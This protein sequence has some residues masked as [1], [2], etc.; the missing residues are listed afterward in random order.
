MP[1][2]GRASVVKSRAYVHPVS[3]RTFSPFSSW[4]EPGCELVERGYSI[5][6]SGD[7]TVGACRP[8]FTTREEAQAFADKWNSEHAV[9]L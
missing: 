1:F 9:S 5:Q 8:P 3:G 2:C 4:R 7:G 6:W